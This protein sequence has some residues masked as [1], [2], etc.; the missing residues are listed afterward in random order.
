MN[1]K[2]VVTL[3]CLSLQSQNLHIHPYYLYRT[4]TSSKRNS[5]A[6]E[7]SI[8]K[9]YKTFSI[10]LQTRPILR[11]DPA[12][13]WQRHAMLKPL[14]SSLQSL[15]NN[16]QTTLT[17]HITLLKIH[18][19]LFSTQPWFQEYWL[20]CVIFLKQQILA[21]LEVLSIPPVLFTS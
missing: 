9:N 12:A 19:D 11:S 16:I 6:A 2:R 20:T 15:N 8:P 5:S 21:N 7:K 3:V 18:A 13:M 4:G 10:F 17:I 1:A 14:P